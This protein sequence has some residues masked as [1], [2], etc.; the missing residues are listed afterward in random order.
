MVE[1]VVSDLRYAVRSWFRAPGFA[2]AAIVTIALGVGANTATFSL[3]DA[4]LL[5]PL[6]VVDPY[7]L[8]RIGSLENNGMT[9]AVPSGVL[10]A[11]RREPLL[12][13]VCGIQTP[14]SNVTLNDA[15]FPVGTHALR[16]DCYG[17]LGVHAAL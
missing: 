13:G 17:T 15:T 4:L 2:A 8:I 3:L 7:R 10:D 6:P 5:R 11:L 16:G 14:V 1:G 12:E 9:V